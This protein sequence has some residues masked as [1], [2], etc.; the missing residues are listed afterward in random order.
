MM[1]E[2]RSN[3][4]YENFNPIFN[5]DRDDHIEWLRDVHSTDL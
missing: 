4:K 3:Q 1:P 2:Q 5:I